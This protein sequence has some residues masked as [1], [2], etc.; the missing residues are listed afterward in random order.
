MAQSTALINEI[1][2][3]ELSIDQLGECSGG[4][5]G[6][7]LQFGKAVY[8]GV[9]EIKEVEETG[10]LPERFDEPYFDVGSGDSDSNKGKTNVVAG[11]GDCFSG[12][13]LPG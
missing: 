4:M 11:P 6:I 9:K 3:Q 12:L 1:T 8:K 10:E 5:I 2:D 13:G 7:I